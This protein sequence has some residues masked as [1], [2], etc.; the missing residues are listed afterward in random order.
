[1][2]RRAWIG[3]AVLLAAFVLAPSAVQAAA[4]RASF[5]DI[6]DEVMCITC[7]VPLNIAVSVQADEER[8]Q[9]RALIAQGLTKQQVLDRLVEDLGP[10]ILADPPRDGFNITT[11]LVPIG[12][13]GGVGLLLLLTIPRWRARRDDE[14]PAAVTSTATGPAPSAD[15]LRRLDDDLAA[16]EV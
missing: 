9:I 15:D 13:V 1:M 10:Q 16:T 4:P 12:A 8:D 5:N 2:I 7:N 3:L 6:E 11:W 14:D